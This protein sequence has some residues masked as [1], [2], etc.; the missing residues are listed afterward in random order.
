MTDE[1]IIAYLLKDLP[2]EELERFEDEC[3]T[4]EDWPT[5]VELVEEDLIE[6][7]L[8][9][10]LVPGQRRSFERNY[11]TTTAR[12]ERVRIAAAL[13]CHIDSCAPAVAATAA[14]PVKQT[15]LERLRASQVVSRWVPIPAV[16]A[17]MMV[18]IAV[19]AWWFYGSPAS[20]KRAE[21][22]ATL[23]LTINSGNRAEGAQ[24]GRVRLTNDISVLRI[25]LTLPASLPPATQYRVQLED[26]RGT[27]KLSENALPEAQSIRV[28]VPAT[29][30][31]RGQ[32]AVKLYAV[33]P[34]ETE[35]RIPGSYLF[36]VE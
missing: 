8:R 7:Y 10:E 17:L 31:A 15:W 32:Y 36:I 29:Q 28:T 20:D 35:Q 4:S 11:L 18:A 30:L 23:T 1:R 19:G 5:Q 12:M 16:V 34:G 6:D 21:T 26:E 2:E 33:K 22:F 27:I 13:L 14:P 25:V 24:A 3:F 9:N